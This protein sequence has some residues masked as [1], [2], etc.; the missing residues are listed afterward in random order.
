MSEVTWPMG[1]VPRARGSRPG[2]GLGLALQPGQVDRSQDGR[3]DRRGRA[4]ASG[5]RPGTALAGRCGSMPGVG[6]Q[7]SG[8]VHDRGRDAGPD[9]GLGGH[10]VAAA[11]RETP[12]GRR[13]WRA[14]AGRGGGQDDGHDRGPGAAAAVG[15]RAACRHPGHVGLQV[16]SDL[17]AIRRG[18]AVGLVEDHDL[19]GQPGQPR[20]QEVVVEGRIVVLLRVG[21][22]GHGVD[23]GQDGL[24]PGAMLAGH[25]V[26]VR[27]VQ[28]GHRSEVGGGMLADILDADPGQQRHERRALG[29]RDP[30][31]RRARRRAPRRGGTDRGCRPAR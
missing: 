16:Q 25:R 28:D 18:Q 19:A 30:G 26:H 11:R 2:G 9:D 3:R 14:A 21:H 17:P 10:P 1:P 7:A 20:P 15:A 23:P 13:S 4:G 8:E 29:G 24:D 12:R 22:P 6:G 5:R 31:D 27:Q